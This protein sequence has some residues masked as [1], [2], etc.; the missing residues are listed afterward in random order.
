MDS[1]G[2]LECLFQYLWGRRLLPDPQVHQA[3]PAG[4]APFRAMQCALYNSRPILGGQAQYQWV[5]FHGGESIR[6]E[7]QALKAT[8]VRGLAVGSFPISLW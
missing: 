2:Q 5:P 8:G 3:C 6:E 4:T 1:L 7:S